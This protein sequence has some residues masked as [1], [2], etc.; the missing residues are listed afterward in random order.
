MKTLKLTD[1]EYLALRLVLHNYL[2]W[3]HEE[4]ECPF[5]HTHVRSIVDNKLGGKYNKD[6]LDKDEV[7]TDW[8]KDRGACNCCGGT[9]LKSELTL[10]EEENVCK[11]CL[12]EVYND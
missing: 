12:A 7:Y 10:H 6:L 5:S 8:Y 3:G 9:F 11:E 4:Q 2:E 1:A